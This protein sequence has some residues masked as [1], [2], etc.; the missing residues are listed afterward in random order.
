MS[1]TPRSPRARFAPAAALALAGLVALA[2]PAAAQSI[3]QPPDGDNQYAS[4]TQGIGPV[5]VTIT[6]H[7]PD[8]HGP[9][10][11]DRTGKIWGGLVPY[12]LHDLQFNDCTA[13]P[14]R[15]G[16]NE[17][18][19]I[20]VS[21]D[22]RV[23][24]RPLPAGSYGLHMIA[25]PEEWTIIFSRNHT[26]WGSYSYDPAE[27]ALRVT[28]RPSAGDYHEWLTYEFTDRQP[29]RA[30]VALRWE[31]LQVPFTVSVEDVP[32]LYLG[33]IRNELRSNPGFRWYN[34]QAA[35]AYALAE[36]RSLDEALGWAAAA[37]SKP[38]VGQ[39]NFATLTTLSQLE[40]ANG[41][42]AEAARTMER[43]LALRD[44]TPI[45]VHMF[46]R[47]L[48][49]Q[50]RKD[51]ALR[52]FEANAKR[53]PGQWPVDL[54]LARAHADAGDAKRALA[55]ARKALSA[56]PDEPSRRGVEALVKQI[57]AGGGGR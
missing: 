21:H 2:A 6:Y 43:A 8:V 40:E 29:D 44:I 56:A 31:K 32:A 27:D 3:S 47:G 46:A 15:A 51:L 9:G 18:T 53:F 14:W 52:V 38:G 28:V 13:C 48:Q 39:A 12:G 26:S 16:A 41:R 33:M 42:E 10:G 35:A 49:A 55:H 23:E 24:G 34:L 7:S 57:E 37:V 17:N 50:G 36:R 54:G 19:V 25:G 30:T 45:Q 1:R 11:E 22:V 20:S 5:R 4:V